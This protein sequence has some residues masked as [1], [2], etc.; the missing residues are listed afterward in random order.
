MKARKG[1]N[2]KA[3]KREKHQQDR[4]NKS[5]NS[6]YTDQIKVTYEDGNSQ[7]GFN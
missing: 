1:E 3:N 6:H 7:I 4:R 5:N 2:K